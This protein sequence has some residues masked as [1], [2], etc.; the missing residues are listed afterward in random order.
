MQNFPQKWFA[1]LCNICYIFLK[2]HPDKSIAS[3]IKLIAWLY[4]VTGIL[5]ILIIWFFAMRDIEW[6]VCVSNTFAFYKVFL[7]IAMASF[8]LFSGLGSAF[9]ILLSDYLAGFKWL[10]NFAML[11]GVFQLITYRKYIW[12]WNNWY[13]VI[14]WIC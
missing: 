14:T 2:W 1:W 3:I 9:D 6:F 7:Y 10:P 8:E 5:S 13:W 11:F 4:N 12:L